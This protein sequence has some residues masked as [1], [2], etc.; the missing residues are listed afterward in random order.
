MNTTLAGTVFGAVLII[1]GCAAVKTDA[2]DPIVFAHHVHTEQ[3]L[4]CAD[5]HTPSGQARLALMAVPR[6]PE[7]AMCHDV[8][9]EENCSKC[10]RQPDD[11]QTF[12]PRQRRI[13]FSHTEHEEYGA[14]CEDCHDG[15]A[16]WPMGH[17]GEGLGH[18]DCRDCHKEAFEKG[19][20]A[21][22]H[23]RLAAEGRAPVDVYA[24]GPNFV[25]RHGI[26]AKGG[27]DVCLSC[28]TQS[29][30]ADCHS[31]TQGVRPSVRYPE[32]VGRTFMHQGDWISRHAIE[33]RVG[34][35]SCLKC[36]QTDA[37]SSCHERS[38]VGAG[39]SK[40][41]PHPADWVLPGSALSHGRAARRRITE[42]AACHDQGP[43]SNCL[44]CH[45]PLGGHRAHNPHPPGWNPPVPRSEAPS[46]QMCSICHMN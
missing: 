12:E 10:H 19:S 39:R 9:S 30:C 28:H 7:C 38:G 23:Q 2:Q 32:E 15:A 27:Q 41:S 36:H 21:M 16:H 44:E 20:C 14:A 40:A 8:E 4:G 45:S 11:P 17:D 26:E 31:K 29:F 25:D 33:S 5:C 18:D 35:S 43:A 37:C 13:V 22:C 3:G 46:H 24:H 42:C 34:D 6:K 1:A